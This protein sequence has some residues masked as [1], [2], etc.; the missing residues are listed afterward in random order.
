MELR[1]TIARAL[2]ASLAASLVLAAVLAVHARY[3][4]PF[5]NMT[6]DVVT[7]T[8]VHLLTGLVSS[9][10]ILCWC[11][12]ATACGLAAALLAPFRSSMGEV[13]FLAGAA[14]LSAYLGLDDLFVFHEDLALRVF[15]IDEKVV[16]GSIGLATLAV[17]VSCR[18]LIFTRTQWALLALALAWLS[19]SVA[20][21]TVLEQQMFRYG[22]WMY[23]WED[24]AK[25]LGLVA[26]AAYWVGTAR[27]LVAARLR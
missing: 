16:I 17:L 21:D 1:T 4:M 10:G 27:D 13:R 14:L 22:D 8:D 6:R 19:V 25:W 26:W 7:V 11:V 24:G 2:L 18:R 23:F 15:G 20:L 5:G 9:L 3:G 12:S